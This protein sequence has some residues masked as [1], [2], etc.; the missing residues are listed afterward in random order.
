MA[1]DIVTVCKALATV[2]NLAEAFD[3]Q[4]ISSFHQQA[5]AHLRS[6]S[7]TTWDSEANVA[8][9]NNVLA[10]VNALWVSQH[11]SAH[12]GPSPT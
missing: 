10:A 5:L 12:F 11:T 1:Q 6:V 8:L 4:S 9:F 2:T 3:L 7:R